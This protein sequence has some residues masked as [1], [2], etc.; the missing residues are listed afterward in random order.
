MPLQVVLSTLAVASVAITLARLIAQALAFLAAA[1]LV[2]RGLGPIERTVVV[3][4]EL[5]NHDE[6]ATFQTSSSAGVDLT[7]ES[8]PRCSCHTLTL[9]PARSRA[10]H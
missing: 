6:T 1:T 7:T 4:E 10:F 8:V 2:R 5:R 3:Q 9:L